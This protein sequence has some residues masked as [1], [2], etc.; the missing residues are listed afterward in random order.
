MSGA[1]Y[2]WQRQ[3]AAP[4]IINRAAYSGAGRRLRLWENDLF[5]D[6]KEAFYLSGG[7]L[8]DIFL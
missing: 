3:Q 5:A 2:D 8:T 7:G 4:P 1:V 6:S